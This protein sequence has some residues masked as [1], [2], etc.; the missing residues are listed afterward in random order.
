MISIRLVFEMLP[1]L[2]AI[3]A[4]FACGYKILTIRRNHDRLKY[5][6][7]ILCS[8]LLIIAQSSWTYTVLKGEIYGTDI[9]NIVRTLFNSLVMLTFIFSAKRVK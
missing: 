8:I 9:A 7:M 5:I 4:I 6:L 1:I 2:L 3:V